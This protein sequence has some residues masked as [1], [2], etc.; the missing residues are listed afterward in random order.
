MFTLA[1]VARHEH[2]RRHVE[3]V[4]RV[5]EQVVQ[6]HVLKIEQAVREDDQNY[7]EALDVVPICRAKNFFLRQCKFSSKN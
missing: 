3:H 2:E 5:D 4:N 1:E 6:R 7:Q